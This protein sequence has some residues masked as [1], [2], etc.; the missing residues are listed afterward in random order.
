MKTPS[1]AKKQLEARAKLAARMTGY[2]LR[3]SRLC[4][5]SVDN[6]GGFR[7]I[8][9]ATNRIAAGEHF[10]LTSDQVIAWVN[11]R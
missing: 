9:A 2:K 4:L 7:L 5:G 11:A 10:D 8:D 3:K 1:R 6:Q